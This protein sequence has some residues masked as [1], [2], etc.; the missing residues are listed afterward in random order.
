MAWLGIA[1]ARTRSRVA[2]QWE[3][4]K[5]A[6]PAQPTGT[7]RPLVICAA[8][9][10]PTDGPPGRDVHPFR[11]MS[12]VRPG[13]PGQRGAL[14]LGEAGLARAAVEHP[15]RLVLS[16][17]RLSDKDGQEQKRK[18]KRAKVR[19]AK[20]RPSGSLR[21]PLH[22]SFVICPLSFVIWS[23][24]FLSFPDSLLGD[25]YCDP[26][27]SGGPPEAEAKRGPR[28]IPPTVPE[29]RVLLLQVV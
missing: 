12:R 15:A 1:R 19:G 25:A 8:L 9:I 11:D 24:R 22:S 4:H 3:G 27:P 10:H 21:F 5:L 26:K 14:A 18:K 28:L 13:V 23:L 2:F 6:G 7:S 20:N 16:L 17:E 29:V